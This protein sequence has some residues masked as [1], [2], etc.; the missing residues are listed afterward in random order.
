MNFADK[1]NIDKGR[2]S[3]S[4]DFKGTSQNGMLAYLDETTLKQWWKADIVNIEPILNGLFYISWGNRAS[5]HEHVLYGVIT[6]LDVR[7]YVI[8]ISK[9]L[10]IHPNGKM[11]NIKLTIQFKDLAPNICNIH[12]VQQH[13]FT[14][15]AKKEHDNIVVK[16]WPVSMALLKSF[17]EQNVSSVLAY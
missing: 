14:G 3:F 13:N 11:E 5:Q 17:L 12:L 1:I 4:F 6:K 9:V 10:Y 16:S 7:E 2:A 8:E 15:N